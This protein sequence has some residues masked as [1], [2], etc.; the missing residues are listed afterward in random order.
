[1]NG[2]YPSYVKIIFCETCSTDGCNG[3]A[4]DPVIENGNTIDERIYAIDEKK[5]LLPG[6]STAISPDLSS[7]H[8]V[9]VTKNVTT[10]NG[11]GS[12][13]DDNDECIVELMLKIKK[14][15]KR[16]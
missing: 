6:E 1:M 7:D 4:M 10:C 8:E 11:T 9:L 14:S 5:N 3:A 15:K 12:V 13:Q 2:N 16:N